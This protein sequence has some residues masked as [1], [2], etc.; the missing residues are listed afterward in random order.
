M[1]KSVL[2]ER[3]LFMHPGGNIPG[4]ALTTESAFVERQ[5]TQAVSSGSMDVV[6][7][8]T[9]NSEQIDLQHRTNGL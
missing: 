9:G 7:L 3:D 6:E 4:T 5:V 8:V 2:N 1:L